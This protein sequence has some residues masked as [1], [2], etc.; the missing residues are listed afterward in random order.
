MPVKSWTE[1]EA[2]PQTM[3]NGQEQKKEKDKRFVKR[4]IVWHNRIDTIALFALTIISA[5]I[6]LLCMLTGFKRTNLLCIITAM[7]L[8]LCI[9][10]LCLLRKNYGVHLEKSI[11]K[12]L[13]RKCADAD[14]AA[15]LE[16]IQGLDERI[17]H[18]KENT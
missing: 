14:E 12:R 3:E 10:Q 5:G 2:D 13:S 16:L 1:S 17:F 8:I 18:E 11:R 9:V 4:V 15:D 7:F 6:T